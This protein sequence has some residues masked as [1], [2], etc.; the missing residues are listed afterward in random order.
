MPVE[1]IADC[2]ESMEDTSVPQPVRTSTSASSD[3]PERP[4][5]FREV[6]SNG[7][8]RAIFSATALSWLGDYLAKIAVTVLVFERT[9]SAGAAAATF[10]ISFAPWLLIGPV[11]TALAERLPR[12]R[13][14]IASDVFRLVTIGL[15]A[16]VDMPV[17]LVIGLL[18]LTALGNPPY[19]AARAA[20][21]PTILVGDRLVIGVASVQ[22]AGQAAQITGYL[23]GGYLAAINPRIALGIDAATFAVSALL[24]VA[25]VRSRPAVTQP[26]RRNLLRETADGFAL[27]FS[28]PALRGIALLIFSVMVVGA[29]PEGL[30]VLWAQT[31]AA[32]DDARRGLVQGLIMI[33]PSLGFIIGGL[34]VGRMLN[35]ETRR[36]LLRPLA[37]LNAAVLVPALFNPPL[38]VV[39][40][41]G[42]LVGV[43][44]A[45]ILP[46]ANRLFVQALPNTHRARAFGV[47]QSGMQL[48]QGGSIAI[49]GALAQPASEVPR[50]IG[51][52]S[53]AGLGLVLVVALLIWPPQER[54]AAAI[55]RANA[56]NDARV[57]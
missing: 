20:L 29:L 28:T 24:I 3:P 43:C 50:V 40:A 14:M 27:V 53:L 52:W 15:V 30:G 54:F 12:R 17:P 5:T 23:L 10:A 4:A 34:V 44:I 48:L 25:F 16:L 31:L 45:G 46:A 26:E 18:F 8:Y 21:M 51:L 6:F 38:P 13:V 41:M 7:E 36:R 39:C 22:S 37:I 1:D 2:C 35:P 49:A 55:E 56:L 33:S 57:A 32:T 9:G 19:D 47:I 11:L 42:F